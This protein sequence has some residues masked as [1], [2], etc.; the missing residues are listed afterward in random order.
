MLQKGK[1]LY[2]IIH[3]KCP[4][5]HEGAIFEEAAYFDIK[6]M[7]KNHDACPACGQDYRIEPG[8]YWGALYIAYGFSVFVS[9][10]IFLLF[11][12]I[13]GFSLNASFFLLVIADLILTPFLYK[14]SKTLWL[15]VFVRYHHP[16]K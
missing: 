12:L 14:L 10:L 11:F 3:Q 9:L 7:G 8:F 5:C 6:K 15:H 1:K 2:G 16:S 13:F 4:A